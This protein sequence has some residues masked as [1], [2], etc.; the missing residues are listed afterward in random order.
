MHHEPEIGIRVALVG[1]D[2][3]GLLKHWRLP[4]WS[5]AAN[6][7]TLGVNGHGFIIIK[8]QKHGELNRRL[9][10]WILIDDKLLRKGQDEEFKTMH[11]FRG[12]TSV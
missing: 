11:S 2:L 1:N 12:Q 3:D 7:S 4:A 5:A 9:R 10:R 6:L 8:T